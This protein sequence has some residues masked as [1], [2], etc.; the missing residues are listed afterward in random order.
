MNDIIRMLDRGE[1]CS[2]VVL[3]LSAA[4][5]TIDH[6]ILFDVLEKR[7]GMSHDAMKWMTSYFEG[8]TRAFRADNEDAD[9]RSL[10]FAVQTV[11]RIGC[12][13]SNFLLLH[14][15]PTRSS[16]V[17]RPSISHTPV[18]RRQPARTWIPVASG[19]RAA[20]NQF[21]NGAQAADFN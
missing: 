18:C 8:R 20:S 12:W 19:S 13:T 14:G 15:G 2:T 11:W 4:F 10:R 1:F 21:A 17:L 7:F 16:D 3:D 6:G 5:D 9:P